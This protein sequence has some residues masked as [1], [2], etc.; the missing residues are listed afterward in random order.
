MVSCH[1]LLLF[2]CVL[3]LNAS[4]APFTFVSLLVFIVF[5]VSIFVSISVFPRSAAFGTASFQ[6]RFWLILC[7]FNVLFYRPFSIV[8]PVLQHC[9]C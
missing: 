9:S 4:V 6:R 5:N 8:V 2:F 7:I 1:G 3:G